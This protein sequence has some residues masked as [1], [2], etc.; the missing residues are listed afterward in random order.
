MRPKFY[1]AL[2]VMMGLSFVFQT[3]RAATFEITPPVQSQLDKQKT[4]IAS[5]ASDPVIVKEVQQQ[6]KKGP[7]PGMNN[8]TWKT[9][10]RSDPVVKTFQDN[11]AGRFLK[12]KLEQEGSIFNEAF[13][14]AAQGEKAAFVEKT[15]FY[16]HKGKPKFDVPFTTGKSWQGEPE[17]DESSQTYAVQISTPVLSEGKPIGVLV[18]G[19]NLSFLEKFKK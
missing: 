14:S 17:F 3:A 2:I 13:L 5:W 19:V 18:V 16:I 9:T 11:P 10:R 4:E 12:A 6:N 8:D 15:T 1:A 7:L